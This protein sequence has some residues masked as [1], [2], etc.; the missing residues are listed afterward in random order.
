MCE[1]IVTNEKKKAKESD[2]KSHFG[3]FADDNKQG[4]DQHSRHDSPVI[5]IVGDSSRK[6]LVRH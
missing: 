5:V 6:E 4:N 1:H 2:Q 3:F